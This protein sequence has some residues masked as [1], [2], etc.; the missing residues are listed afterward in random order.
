MDPE[1]RALLRQARRG[2]GRAHVASLSALGVLH[3][4]GQSVSMTLIF[5]YACFTGGPAFAYAAG[6]LRVLAGLQERGQALLPGPG[7]G[8]ARPEG[9]QGQGEAEAEVQGTTGR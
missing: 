9:L 5:F 4:N 7:H 8:G 2:A 6:R 1:F 3:C